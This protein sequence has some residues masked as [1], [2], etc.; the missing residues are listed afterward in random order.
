M[1]PGRKGAEVA[2]LPRGRTV[3]ILRASERGTPAEDAKRSLH[4]ADGIRSLHGADLALVHGRTA[5]K[6]GVCADNAGIVRGHVALGGGGAPGRG[7]VA[8]GSGCPCRNFTMVGVAVQ[9]VGVR[10]AGDAQV[11]GNATVGALDEARLAHALVACRGRVLAAGNTLGD[12][13]GVASCGSE[14]RYRTLHGHVVR[15]ANTLV[16]SPI[17]DLARTAHVLCVVD[18]ARSHARQEGQSGP[19]PIG[20]SC[21]AVLYVLASAPTPRRDS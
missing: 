21:L 5:T 12:K 7:A 15:R 14:H 6:A 3:P 18:A 20:T 9:A 17:L 8:G 1:K 13:R 4:P 16:Q 19:D 2:A 10:G 11:A